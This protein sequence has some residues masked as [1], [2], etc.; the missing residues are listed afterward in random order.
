MG[1]VRWEVDESRGGGWAVSVDRLPT[2]REKRMADFCTE[3]NNQY[4][5]C[6]NLSPQHNLV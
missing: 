5:F 2:E 6:Y 4:N 3:K 1:E